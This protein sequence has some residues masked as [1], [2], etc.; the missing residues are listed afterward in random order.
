MYFKI[1]NHYYNNNHFTNNVNWHFVDF[2]WKKIATPKYFVKKKYITVFSSRYSQ[3]RLAN[4]GLLNGP[5]HG[6][7]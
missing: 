1:Q 2:T 6:D 7:I 5:W 4:R 3:C